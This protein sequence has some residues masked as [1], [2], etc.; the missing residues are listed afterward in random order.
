MRL[1]STRTL[2]HMTLTYLSLT[3]I[4]W[5][6]LQEEFDS[7]SNFIRRKT[8]HFFLCECDE[9]IEGKFPTRN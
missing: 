6:L 9:G 5:M 2:N 8:K 4:I 1:T 7:L 3:Y